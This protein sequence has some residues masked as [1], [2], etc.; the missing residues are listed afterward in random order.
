MHYVYALFLFLHIVG[1]IVLLGGALALAVLNF[2][3]SHEPARPVQEAVSRA[4]EFYGR[5]LLGPATGL[6][7]AAGVVL[8]G[9][10]GWIMPAWIIW[11]FCGLAAS[12]IL[13]AF[14][15]RRGAQALTKFIA[16]GAGR[17]GTVVLRRRLVLL[18][19]LNLL[20]LLSAVWAM[21]FKPTV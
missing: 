6:T 12:G 3:I 19:A 1:V 10:S 5:T 14:P 20:I 7:L 18:N 16:T 15:I 21:V 13:C 8:I 4:S 2:R 9:I 11:G 17:R